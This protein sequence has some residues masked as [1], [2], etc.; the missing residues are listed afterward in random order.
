MF[1]R[2][3]GQ[4]STVGWGDSFVD[5]AN[6]GKLDLILANGAI[7][8]TNMKQDTEP[9]QVLQG[10]GHA[11]FTN[12]SGIVDPNGMP[13]IIGRG[14]AAADFANNGHMAIAINS[15]GGPLVLLRNES[16]A[17]NWLEVN[18]RPFSP[19][20]VVTATL[21]DGR[22]LVREVQAGSSYLSSED[23]RVHFGLGDAKTAGLTV[24]YPD[25]SVRRLAQV[26]AN[27]ILSVSPPG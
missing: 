6:N 18:V 24:R 27:R 16:K 5:L 7:P 23:P 22:R 14:L 26:R 11:R 12:A 2:V 10:L 9:V 25:G 3:L 15:I 20:A 17:G 19:G 8:I 21:P 13:R 1:A 4:R